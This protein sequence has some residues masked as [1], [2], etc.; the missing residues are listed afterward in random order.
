MNLP[1]K[2]TLLMRRLA[3]ATLTVWIFAQVLCSAH[4]SF[5][6][7]SK[8][9][10]DTAQPACHGGSCHGQKQ[11]PAPGGSGQSSECVMLM[12]A[13]L[14]S[15]APPLDLP[16]FAYVVVAYIATTIETEA[17]PNRATSRQSSEPEMANTLEV[18]PG[19]AFR[20]LAPPLV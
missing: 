20:S 15:G 3:A 6:P 14:L 16:D 2:P 12:K 18:S 19:P 4:C 9:M 17:A 13:S 11:A 10:S 1:G 5:N 8:M 7:A